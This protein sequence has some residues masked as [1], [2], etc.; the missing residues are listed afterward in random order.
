MKL[1]DNWKDAWKWYSVWAASAVVS[2]GGIGAYL[3]PEMIAAPV[4]FFPDWTWGKVLSSLTAFFGVTGIIGR[5]V[6][7]ASDEQ[8]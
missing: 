4:L 6:S 2:I 7:Q 5:L 1:I 3:T 8:G